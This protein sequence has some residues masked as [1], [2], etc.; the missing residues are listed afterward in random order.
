[1]DNIF[2]KLIG[3]V[4]DMVLYHETIRLSNNLDKK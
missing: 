4:S 3:K 1:M 2:N